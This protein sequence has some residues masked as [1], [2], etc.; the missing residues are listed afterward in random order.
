MK[1]TSTLTQN[2]LLNCAVIKLLCKYFYHF[3]VC[4]WIVWI[5]SLTTIH[6]STISLDLNKIDLQ[7]NWRQVCDDFD[8]YYCTVKSENDLW[9]IQKYFANLP[10]KVGQMVSLT[11]ETNAPMPANV[12]SNFSAQEIIISVDGKNTVFEVRQFFKSNFTILNFFPGSFNKVQHIH[13]DAF[14]ASQHTAEAV[15]INY[16]N[17]ARSNF[18]FLDSFSILRDLRVLNSM[19]EGFQSTAYLPA[20]KYIRLYNCRGLVRWPFPPLLTPNLET[21]EVKFDSDD[22]IDSV[23]SHIKL[24]IVE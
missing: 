19:L 21:V 20:V 23:P 14:R 10:P 13:S 11:F 4:S 2:S 24:S 8:S 7:D 16:S 18:S 5:P 12:L 22:F 17:L 6:A 1:D 3:K 15:H 9:L